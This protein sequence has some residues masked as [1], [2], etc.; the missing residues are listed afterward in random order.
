MPLSEEETRQAIEAAARAAARIA[1]G[2]RTTRN[3]PAQPESMAARKKAEVD[4]AILH[5]NELNR[6]VAKAG[7]PRGYEQH[8]ARK[9]ED[10]SRGG[11]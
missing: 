10:A 9:R 4:A 2:D 8:K 5:S 11:R 1:T 6:G 7:E 3:M